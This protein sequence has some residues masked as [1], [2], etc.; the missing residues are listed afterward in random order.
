[1]RKLVAPSLVT[2]LVLSAAAVIAADV[3]SGLQQGEKI[4]AFIVTKCAGNPTDGVAEGESLCYRCKMGNRPV[5]AVFA[6][7]VDDNLV[8][9]VKELDKVVAQNQDKKMASFVN[10]IGENKDQLKDDAKQLVET[11]GVEN[12]AVV[13]PAEGRRGWDALKLSDDADVTVLIFK[14][15]KIAANH[16]V[17][18]GK[19]NQDKIA[20]IVA[21][22]GK[23]LK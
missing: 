6:H 3:K 8:S 16:A 15:G 9:L 4:N 18:P 20:A 21:D 13:V 23:I 2:A 17:A 22:T 5:A 11:A 1:M 10:L 19:L 7:S 14:D 12:I